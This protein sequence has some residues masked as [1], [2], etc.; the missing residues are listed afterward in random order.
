MRFLSFDF[1]APIN[2]VIVAVIVLIQ[3]NEGAVF[4][5][6]ILFFFENE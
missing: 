4:S 6:A 1:V 5:K 2:L 3:T